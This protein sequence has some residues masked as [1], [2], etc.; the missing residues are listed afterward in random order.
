MWSGSEELVPLGNLAIGFLKTYCMIIRLIL[1]ALEGF[2]VW[3][4]FGNMPVV[5]R[6]SGITDRK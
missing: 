5:Q 6:V 4:R 2:N 3:M 1:S